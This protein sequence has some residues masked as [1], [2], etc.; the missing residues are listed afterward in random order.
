MFPFGS[1]YSPDQQST[2][3]PARCRGIRSTSA[4]GTCCLV[5]LSGCATPQV[6]ALL[7][8]RPA[9]LPVS[10]SISVPYFAQK[11][12]QCGPAALAMALDAAGD[13]VTPPDLVGS[14]FIPARE[15]SLPPEML[16]A[17]RRRSRLAVELDPRI[18]AV[19]AEVAAGTPVIVLQNVS[20]PILPIWHYSVVVG[21]DLEHKDIILQS[22]GQR[23]GPLAL[24]TFERTWARSQRWAMVVLPPDRLP[25]S[26]QPMHLFAAVAA[27]E[28]IDPAAARQAYRLITRR[29]PGFVPAWVGLGNAAYAQGD[30]SE[31]AASFQRA[32][33]LDPKSA[34]AWNNLASALAALGQPCE[35][36]RAVGHA[37]QIGGPRAAQYEQT[38]TEIGT[39]VCD[40]GSLR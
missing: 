14:V 19:L 18:D 31:S 8:E 38:A 26:P 21:Y 25:V 34:D 24:R 30:M 2:M 11:D 39:A 7:R 29:S 6:D 32:T 17:A 5:L 4:I 36:A 20:L 27:L 15:G 13:T 37:I 33:E 23:A 16:A 10:H 9:Q 22:G 12:H 28:R 35:A 3:P 1:R 40:D